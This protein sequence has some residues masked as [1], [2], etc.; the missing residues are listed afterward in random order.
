MAVT[1]H[2]GHVGVA[3]TED[4][5]QALQGREGKRINI[6]RRYSFPVLAPS[7]PTSA[8]RKKLFLWIG[9][10]PRRARAS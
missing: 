10:Q 6:K 4:G 7:P 1:K 9:Q 5:E 3:D 2:G 8:P